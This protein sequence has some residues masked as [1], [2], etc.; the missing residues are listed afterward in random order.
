MKCAVEPCLQRAL[1][2]ICFMC[3][4]HDVSRTYCI[5]VK[6]SDPRESCHL[7]IRHT[8]GKTQ[9]KELHLLKPT[10]LVYAGDHPEQMAAFL[11]KYLHNETQY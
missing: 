11:E 10:T 8:C 5:T 2:L 6:Y 9:V 3:N 7:L 4:F 1:A